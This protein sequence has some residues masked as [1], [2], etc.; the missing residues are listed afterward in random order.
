MNSEYESS[1]AEVSVLRLL[2]TENTVMAI[3][4]HINKFF[5]SSLILF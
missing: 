5:R 3:K 1:C 2:N 4:S